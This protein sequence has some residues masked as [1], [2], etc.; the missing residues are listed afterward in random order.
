M[1]IRDAFPEA[2]STYMDGYSDGWEYRTIFTGSTLANAYEMVKAFLREEGFGDIPLPA[3]A[4]ELRRFRHPHRNRQLMLFADNGY[5]HNPIKILFPPPG[6]KRPQLILCIYNPSVPGHL[7]RF[8]GK[9][10]G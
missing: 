2:G 9:I 7:L 1:T 3:D 6:G 10:T 5:V 4:G 8:H